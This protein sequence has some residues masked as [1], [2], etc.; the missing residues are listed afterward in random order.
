MLEFSAGY[1]ATAY[2]EICPRNWSNREL[3]KYAALFDGDVVNVSAGM[4]KDKEGRSYKGYFTRA[5]SY[6]ITNY[7]RLYLKE[8]ETTEHILDLSVPNS[9]PKLAYDVVF[10]HTVLEHIFEL[11]VAIDNICL[12]SRDVVITVVPFLQG[13]HMAPGHFSDYW[14]LTPVALK[15]IFSLR[16]FETLYYNWSQ[17]YPLSY[18]YI[19][20][21]ASKFPE[22]YKDCFP[23]IQMPSDPDDAPGCQLNHLLADTNFSM[24]RRFRI[25]GKWLGQ[26]VDGRKAKREPYDNG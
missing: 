24:R 17:S 6:S 19:I 21:I 4:D 10:N 20:H 8:S 18:V 5:S 13:M 16:G 3:S 7:Q 26:H 22:T 14:R 23:K 9:A 2:P 15:K 1:R 12:M 11:D 25:A